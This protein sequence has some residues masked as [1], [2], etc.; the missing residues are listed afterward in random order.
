[1]ITCD[2][3]R[4]RV[5]DPHLGTT[6]NDFAETAHAI[7]QAIV[8]DSTIV[9]TDLGP[10]INALHLIT[11]LR[12]TAGLKAKIVGWHEALPIARKACIDANID[13][14]VVMVGLLPH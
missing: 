10:T 6:S 4:E 2:T 8:W 1:M 13:P 12:A 7:F 9:F 3:W 14:D 5:T 11:A